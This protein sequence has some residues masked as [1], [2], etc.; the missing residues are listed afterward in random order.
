MIGT[1]LQLVPA[2]NYSLTELAELFTKSF[3]K[4]FVE[5][6]D[7]AEMMALRLRV[8]ST[9]LHLSRVAVLAGQ[10][11]GI[12]LLSPRGRAC[13]ISGM[14]VVEPKRGQGIGRR[15][16]EAGIEEL[17]RRSYHRLVLEVIEQNQAAA[18]LYSS[19]GF[20]ERRRLVG[21]ERAPRP[22][23]LRPTEPEPLVEI[24]ARQ[25]AHRVTTE[26]L[27]DLPWQLAAESLLAYTPPNRAFRLGARAV[28]LISDPRRPTI[29][30]QA[31][32]VDRTQRRQGW[33]RR[34]FE[35]LERKFPDRRWQVP[36]RL[37][38][39]TADKF[40]DRLGFRPQ[41]IRQLEMELAIEPADLC[42][43]DGA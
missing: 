40:F 24:D 6:S 5:V 32:V 18:A 23:P 14:G 4:Y 25:V 22:T 41:A 15:L 35:A 29:L 13:R 33:G 34:L 1:D 7:T 26:T 16:L 9:D 31:L 10:G 37:P 17:G 38:E 11:V 2:S 27:N 30:L 39:G 19:L 12:L 43:L 28:A 8:D 20:R 42:R 36:V 21:F 3:A